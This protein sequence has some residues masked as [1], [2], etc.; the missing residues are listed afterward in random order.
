MQINEISIFKDDKA[1]KVEVDIMIL[2]Y[3]GFNNVW[4]YEEAETICFANVWVGKETKD[5]REGGVR[6]RLYEESRN[7]A[8][9]SDRADVDSK[10]TQELHD[11]VD[12]LITRETHCSDNIT[13]HING[14]FDEL[15]NVCV[16]TLI[17]K[18]K[19]KTHVFEKG[20]YLLN[21]NGH[22]VQH[23]S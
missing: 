3:K 6:Y 21:N 10:Y 14:N 20:A 5:Y 15:D 13:Y 22:T 9:G 19:Y 17:D 16:V 8:R 7:K 4:C 2:Q 1:K 12:K 11:A 23:I 18:E